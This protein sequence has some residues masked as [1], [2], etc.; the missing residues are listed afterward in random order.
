MKEITPEEY[1]EGEKD[2]L[3]ILAAMV[4]DD[5]DVLAVF[6]E[7]SD[8]NRVNAGLVNLFFAVL[9]EHD[10]DPAEW[11]AGRQAEWIAAEAQE[12]DR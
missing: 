4:R 12:G 10:V 2:A 6:E 1:A 11:I 8:V 7:Q 5:W 3:A 9:A